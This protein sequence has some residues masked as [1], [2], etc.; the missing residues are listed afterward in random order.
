MHCFI[1]WPGGRASARAPRGTQAS[2]GRWGGE[3]TGWKRWNAGAQE[4]AEYTRTGSLQPCL[5][6]LLNL[7]IVT[8]IQGRF[9]NIKSTK[10][11]YSPEGPRWR[12]GGG[13]GQGDWLGALECWSA[14]AG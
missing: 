12:Q 2:A 4:A 7:Y 5:N 6:I 10:A 9:L 13:G 14:G 3:G 1:S 11:C 8:Q